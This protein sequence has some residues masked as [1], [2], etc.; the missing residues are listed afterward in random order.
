MPGDLYTSMLAVTGTL[1]PDDAAEWNQIKS[2]AVA[3]VEDKYGRCSGR[4]GRRGTQE[5]VAAACEESSGGTDDRE[6]K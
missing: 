4:R 3:V 5:V 1:N 6:G 2:S